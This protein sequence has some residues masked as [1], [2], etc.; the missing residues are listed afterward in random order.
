MVLVGPPGAGKTTV[1]Q[2]VAARLAVPFRD[3][4]TDVAHRAGKPVLDIF[5]DDGEEAFRA[6][7]REAVAAA[8]AEHPGVAEAAVIGLPDERKG[9]VPVAVIRGHHGACPDEAELIAW[10]KERMADY[11][12][13]GQIRFVEELPRTGTD[14]VQKAKLKELF[15][16]GQ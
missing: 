11:K 2:L 4:D 7:E 1:G 8:L 12:V 10:A 14:K 5:V 13:P 15:G 9:E 6:L 3:T 16:A